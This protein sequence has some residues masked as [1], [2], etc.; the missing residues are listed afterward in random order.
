MWI[1][2]LLTIVVT[3]V[4]TYLQIHEAEKY[5][6]SFV[7]SVNVF[8]KMI[9]F[10]FGVSF[11]SLVIVYVFKDGETDGTELLIV[12][13]PISRTQIIFGKFIV[14]IFAII[15]FSIMMFIVQI[16]FAQMDNIANGM[17]RLK[18]AASISVG[19]AIVIGIAS[20]II[21]LIASFLGKVG[22][23]AIGIVTAATVPVGSSIV[24]E[25]SKGIP[26]RFGTQSIMMINQNQVDDLIDKTLTRVDQ[27]KGTLNQKIQDIYNGKDIL[28]KNGNVISIT[29]AALLSL[30]KVHQYPFPR[31][32]LERYY[33]YLNDRWYNVAMYGDIWYQWNT[34]YSMFNENDSFE[35][36]ETYKAT[37]KET[38]IS[39]PDEYSF[40]NISGKNVAFPVNIYSAD[41]STLDE[42]TKILVNTFIPSESSP[43]GIQINTFDHDFYNEF[44]SLE[45]RVL[46]KQDRDVFV[47]IVSSLKTWKDIPKTSFL[48]Y[49]TKGQVNAHEVTFEDQLRAIAES[50]SA[51]TS[52]NLSL[53]SFS[54]REYLVYKGVMLALNDKDEFIKRYWTVIE[55]V[56]NNKM[57]SNIVK[58]YIQNNIGSYVKPKHI[59]GYGDPTYYETIKNDVKKAEAFKMTESPGLLVDGQKQLVLIKSRYIDKGKIIL[60]WSIIG[61]ALL[62]LT[63]Y[64]YF[65]RDFK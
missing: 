42:V 57:I 8:T 9:P 39:I 33:E 30:E 24:A 13:K 12:S 10:I 43:L 4:V 53:D 3:F 55:K 25:V 14:V 15:G 29:P 6:V 59:Y 20:V 23:V 1:I 45:V 64:R 2:L 27:G 62:L 54:I 7:T 38:K 50:D 51:G 41:D 40:A 36:G 48:D 28:D 60:I 19:G 47:D 16:S 5:Q 17:A 31:R 52:H 49:F 18:F 37:V 32:D 22:T 35:R 11:I 46:T 44:H 56:I 26:L 34:F 65:K 58:N 61:G 21:M 63:I